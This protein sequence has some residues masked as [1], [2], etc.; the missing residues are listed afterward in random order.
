[1]GIVY[2]HL[3]HLKNKNVGY[4]NLGDQ[5]KSRYLKKYMDEAEFISFEEFCSDRYRKR[6]INKM[7]LSSRLKCALYASKT[8]RNLKYKLTGRHR[9]QGQMRLIRLA[10]NLQ[11]IDFKRDVLD[12][13]N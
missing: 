2:F 12:W 5:A 9:P 4:M 13:L 7:S 6:L 8:I 10:S 3:K 11:A 1:M